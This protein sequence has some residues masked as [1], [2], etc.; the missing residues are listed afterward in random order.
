MYVCMYQFQKTSK[1]PSIS[2]QYNFHFF[3]PFGGSQSQCMSMF[4]NTSGRSI[5]IDA[6]LKSCKDENFKRDLLEKFPVNKPRELAKKHPDS[7]FTR[8][9]GM[10]YSLPTGDPERASRLNATS[11][12]L[13]HVRHQ[14]GRELV[15]LKLEGP[16]RDEEHSD[17]E[18][19]DEEH[20][21]FLLQDMSEKL[22]MLEMDIKEIKNFLKEL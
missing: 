18:H 15:C 21:R 22:N 16:H 4:T 17:E 3:S 20:D 19:S 11:K 12:A 14:L 7:D 5:A 1:L 6:I 9:Y 10:A 8:L 13:I 2:K